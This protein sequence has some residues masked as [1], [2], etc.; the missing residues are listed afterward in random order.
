MLGAK[1]SI[2]LLI[3]RRL[4]HLAKAAMLLL[5]KNLVLADYDLMAVNVRLG[6]LLRRAG[7]LEVNIVVVDHSVQVVVVESVVHL[8]LLF[9]AFLLLFLIFSS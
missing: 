8:L 4:L 7:L 1:L 2:S 5:V 9:V 3:S 6:L